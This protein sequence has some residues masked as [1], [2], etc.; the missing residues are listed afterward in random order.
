MSD[1]GNK[2]SEQQGNLYSVEM[3]RTASPLLRF[4]HWYHIRELELR[5]WTSVNVCEK[6]FHRKLDIDPNGPDWFYLSIFDTTTLELIFKNLKH[7]IQKF[8][9]RR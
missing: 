5:S 7:L 1:E 9:W 6:F 2:Q 8:R 3:L 4:E